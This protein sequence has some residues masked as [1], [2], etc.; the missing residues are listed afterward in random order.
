MSENKKIKQCVV[1][2][3]EFELLQ[4]RHYI[5]IDCGESGIATVIGKTTDPKIYDA[6]DCP[7]CG[8]QNV[9]K[10]RKRRY[11]AFNAEDQDDAEE[12]DNE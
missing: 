4:E 11:I 1:C 12:K 6:M 7:R 9:L 3:T 8:C 10:E 2:G 5:A